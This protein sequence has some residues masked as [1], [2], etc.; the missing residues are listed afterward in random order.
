[1]GKNGANIKQGKYFP[2]YNIWIC[3][4]KKKWNSHEKMV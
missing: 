4:M 2:V 3:Q 1:M